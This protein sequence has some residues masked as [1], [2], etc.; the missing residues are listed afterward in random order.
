[1]KSLENYES[2]LS[3]HYSPWTTIIDNFN[4]ANYSI[5]DFHIHFPIMETMPY[6]DMRWMIYMNVDDDSEVLNTQIGQSKNKYFTGE[7]KPGMK[8]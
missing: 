6:H 2:Y 8:H 1:L 7:N 5:E 3:V 4:T